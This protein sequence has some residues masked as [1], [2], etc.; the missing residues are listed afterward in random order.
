MSKTKKHPI[1]YF[2]AFSTQ[3]RIKTSKKCTKMTVFGRFY[4]IFE[5]IVFHLS[6]FWLI[7]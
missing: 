7:L 3:K 6:L 1:Y 5:K 4:I 2:F